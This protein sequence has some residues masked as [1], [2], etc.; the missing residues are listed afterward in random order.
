MHLTI[1]HPAI[2]RRPGVNYMRTWQMES[3][4]AAVLA[5]L[6]P[7]DVTISFHDDRMEGIPFDEPTDLVAISVE[8]YTAMRA[9]QI[10][11]EFRRRGVPVV[12]GGFHATL[13]PDEVSE[14]ADATIL[15]EAEGLWPQV[16][17]DFQN[18]RLQRVYQSPRR[19][20]LANLRPD[21]SI[22]RGKRYL[23]IG[24]IEAGRG[25]H[26]RCEFCAVQSYFKN[27]QT[28]RPTE[29]ILDEIRRMKKP[30]Y[31]FVDD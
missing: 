25:C 26:L 7:K 5:G 2:G 28:R 27:T 14:Y 16:I 24:L 1:V 22:F 19:P 29:E 6:T 10:A 15:G 4:P 8:T 21:R 31:F 13:V 30:L 23:P 17:E 20:A 11:S 18:G 3:L 9:Y 12:M